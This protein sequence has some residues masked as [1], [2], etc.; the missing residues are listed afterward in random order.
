MFAAHH[1]TR[2]KA[3]A[4]TLF[5]LAYLAVMVVVFAP[6]GTFGSGHSRATIVADPSR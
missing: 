4:V 5:T 3:L 1:S 2:S 6:A